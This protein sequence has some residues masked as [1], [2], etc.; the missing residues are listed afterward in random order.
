MALLAVALSIG[1]IRQLEH[2]TY[3]INIYK[4]R[5]LGIWSA[6]HGLFHFVAG[7]FVAMNP[8]YVGAFVRGA[9]ASPSTSVR[10][11]LFSGG[12]I[13]GLLVALL[14]LLLLA[15]SSDRALRFLGTKKWKFL[16]RSSHAVLWLTVLHGIAF[17]VLE[18]RFL[19]MLILSGIAAVLLGFQL[20][21]RLISRQRV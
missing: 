2:R 18:A 14:F 20:R 15:I 3:R 9:T 5:D 16:Q 13:A 7:N 4:R 17:Q 21:A 19:P 11:Q 8:V 10:E 12:S 1:P 6:L